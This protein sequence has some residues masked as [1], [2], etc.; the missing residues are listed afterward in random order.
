[1]AFAGK[2]VKITL[3]SGETYPAKI[4]NVDP[5]TATLTVDRLDTNTKQYVR[6]D[7]L[8][9]VSIVSQSTSDAAVSSNAT[10]TP[11]N[12]QKARAPLP[13]NQTTSTASAQL[14]SSNSAT[15]SPHPD[16]KPRPKSKKAS[17]ATAATPQ[18][19]AMP[20]M[21]EFDYTKSTQNF[22]KKKAWE[23]IRQSQAGQSRDP[24]LVQLNRKQATDS[25]QPML[26]P[27][28]P[29]LSPDEHHSALQR[30]AETPNQATNT[31]LEDAKQEIQTLRTELDRANQRQALLEAFTNVHISNATND[32]EYQCRLYS[33]ARVAAE[34]WRAKHTSPADLSSENTLCYTVRV[35]A[36][37]SIPKNDPVLFTYLGPTSDADQEIVSR[38]PE[39]LCDEISVKMENA[40]L[41]EQRLKSIVQTP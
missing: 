35:P 4:V 11:S 25:R 26:A 2:Q 21:E 24:L 20:Y 41:F 8:K 38:L 28:E 3:H 13:N 33:N 17:N 40:A 36:L 10:P 27:D 1:M 6:R 5:T 19:K 22:D 18:P 29:V 23:E 16:K 15:S 7:E 32:Q 30:D 31:Q 34:H 14:S 39:H 37:A 12:S 9:D